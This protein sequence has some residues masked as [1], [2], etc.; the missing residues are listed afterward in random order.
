MRNTFLFVFLFFIGITTQ[1][2][3]TLK[4]MHYNLLYYGVVTSWCTNDN[5]NVDNKNI[6]L[7]TIL[8]EVQ[9]DILTVNEISA[10]EIV[11]NELMQNTLNV[12]GKD[13]YQ[14][15]EVRNQAGS[16]IV[17]MLYYDSRKLKLKQ[18]YTAQQYVR[19]VDVYELYYNSA[20][21]ALGDTAF[22]VCVVAHLKAGSEE[23]DAATR[24]VMA[25]DVMQF[26]EQHYTSE[27]VLLMGDFNLYSGSEAAY[28]TITNYANIDMRFLDPVSQNG[29]WHNNSAFAEIHTQS[30]NTSS[31]GCASSG[32]MDD[33]FDFILISD[34]VRFGTRS[35]R[36]VT[37]S[38]QAFGQDGNRF[39]GSIINPANTAVSE[40]I[41]TALHQMSDHLPVVLDLRVD[42]VLDLNEQHIKPF[43]AS[44]KPNPVRGLLQLEFYLNKPNQ[45]WVNIYA[46]DGQLINRMVL[47]AL[48]G[49]NSFQINLESMQPGI[50]L[51]QLLDEKGNAEI[52]RVIKA[53]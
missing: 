13:Y 22:V 38:Y 11:Q 9:P 39:N 29:S 19:D 50:Y 28:Q 7:R 16:S 27:N 17:N 18:Q 47:P 36:Y 10:N 35:V 12:D 46:I 48:S 34:E 49:K 14:K 41:A 43:L 3:D 32:G 26:L 21:L 33:R 45:M 2:Q 52:L 53:N 8:G 44:I 40:E 4:V 20:D 15:A 31:N 25:N 6:H 5:N 42:K 37:D 24:N 23:G 51:L 30:T 1:A